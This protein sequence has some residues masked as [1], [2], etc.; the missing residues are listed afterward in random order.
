MYPNLKKKPTV[1]LWSS[2]HGYIC[3]KWYVLMLWQ[4]LSK[5]FQ[6]PFKATRSKWNVSKEPIRIAHGVEDGG[7]D[8]SQYNTLYSR[9]PDGFNQ[10]LTNIS[11]LT[12]YAFNKFIY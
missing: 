3:C 1:A 8:T 9:Q 5:A 7:G 6:F 4:C 11:R 12:G 10:Q 2:N